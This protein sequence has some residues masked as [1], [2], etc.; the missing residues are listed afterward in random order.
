MAYTPKDGTDVH[1]FLMDGSGHVVTKFNNN[2]IPKQITVEWMKA[3]YGDPSK[4]GKHPFSQYRFGLDPLK[5]VL[6]GAINKAAGDPSSGVMMPTDQMEAY[7]QAHDIA[8]T[9][10]EN[11]ENSAFVQ[12]YKVSGQVGDWPARAG[13][14]TDPNNRTERKISGPY[15]NFEKTVGGVTYYYFNPRLNRPGDSWFVSPTESKSEPK[16]DSSMGRV[17]VKNEE[18]RKP[19][20]SMGG[21]VDLKTKLRLA[22]KNHDR[23]IPPKG[24]GGRY[25]EKLRNLMIELKN[26]VGG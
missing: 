13:D 25:A 3:R 16:V 22:I 20:E 5:G 1:W 4:D 2:G 23:D 10:T 17:E 21:V 18:E 19:A 6:P 11:G 8:A 12:K 14:S 26:M 24:E 7:V 15:G 9:L